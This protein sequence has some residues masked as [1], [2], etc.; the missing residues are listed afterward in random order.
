[1][2]DFL[3]ELASEEIPARMQARAAEQLAL[4]FGDGLKGRV[5]FDSLTTYVTPRR[6]ALYVE[7]LGA[8]G[9]A[10]AEERRGPRADAPAAAIDGFLRST[11]LTRE[12]LE[13]RD[14]AKGRFLYA[15]IASV[16]RP[17]ADL[18]AEMVPA[19]VRDFDWP[20]SMRWGA[21]SASTASPRWVRPLTGIVALLDDD[22]VAFEAAGIASGR[23]TMGHRFMAPGPVELAHARDYAAALRAAFVIVDAGER[24][25][26][27]AAQAAAAA[28]AA[29]LTLIDDA[30]LLDENA[31][32]TEWP[33]PLLG[34]FDAAFLDV[35]REIIQL[36]MRTNQKYFACAASDGSLAPAFVAVA[37]LAASDSGAAIVAGNQRVLGARLSDA[38]FFWDQDMAKVRAGG[39]EAFTPK[40]ADIVFHEKLGTVAD[41]VARV[42]KLARWLVESGAVPGADPDH[43]ERAA[44]LCKADLTTATVGE[45]PELQGVIGGYLARVPQPATADSVIPAK[46]GTH[47][48][49]RQEMAPR[50]RGDDIGGVEPLPQPVADAIRDHYKPLGPTDTVPTAPLTI[51]VAL[52][53]KL[54]SLLG[55][56]LIEEVPTG[57]KDPFALRRAALGAIS[58]LDRNS[59]R[60]N[61]EHALN[62]HYLFVFVSF[63]REN[64]KMIAIYRK[65]HPELFQKHRSVTKRPSELRTGPVDKLMGFLIDRLKVQQ[66]EAGVR[67]D[68][69]D[70]VF[71]LGGE[72]DLV[73]LLAR[74][75]AL[76][77]FV[78]TADGANLLAGYRRAANILRD[79]EKRDGTTYAPDLAAPLD[80]YIGETEKN[81]A[82]LFADAEDSSTVLLFDEIDALLGREDFTGAMTALAKLRA[83]VDAFFDGVTVNDPDPATRAR[84]L[85]LLAGVRAAMHR[86]ADFAKIE[87]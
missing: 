24:R 51:A 78:A 7:G 38:K 42:A 37:N 19:I 77:A 41:K 28:R 67:H 76:Q 62:Q 15:T 73:R 5:P 79:E 60:L 80:T 71:A 25:S 30:G 84:R 50:F 61:L 43:A 58:I 9:S 4:R 17:A 57:S 49:M 87:G 85:G 2:P 83:P 55:F 34:R 35:P 11:G 56:Y 81:L 63:A 53:D 52:A 46:A 26:I 21:A 10:T 8:S 69:I 6:L 45:F 75:H 36:T 20:K 14:T 32:L 86:V 59:V 70:A 39:L 16:G 65:R 64:R 54:D 22:V 33:V 66:R 47:L 44:R 13:E 48:P 18:I 3:L 74:V 23:T 12:Q 68:L 1:M 27:I 72:D 29:G 82:R 31:G 40:L